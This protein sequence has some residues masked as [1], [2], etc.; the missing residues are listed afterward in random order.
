[1]YNP[2]MAGNDPAWQSSNVFL[3]VTDNFF[4]APKISEILF[5]MFRKSKLAS[6]PFI[7]SHTHWQMNML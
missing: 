3:G 6:W 4:D 5:G 1:M 2:R 7:T